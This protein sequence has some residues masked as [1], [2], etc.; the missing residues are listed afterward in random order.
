MSPENPLPNQSVTANIQ[1][2]ITDL[3]SAKITWSING[4]IIKTGTGEKTATF[5]TGA[6]NTTTN[7][8]I[9]IVTSDGQSINKS[10]RLNPVFV[11]LMW[12][13][14]SYTPPFYKGKG[15]FSFQNKITFIAMPHIR[16]S[17]GTEISPKNLVYKWRLNGSVVESAS[18]YGKNTYLFTPTVIARPI[19]VRVEVST[20]NST[21]TG[22]AS[23][24][25]APTEPFINFYEKSPIYGIQFQKSISG[26][27]EME[28]SREIAV[29]AVPY[30][31][32][33]QNPYEGLSYKWSI[34]GKLI[35]TDESQ[36]TRVFRQ[37]ENI[38]GSSN[39][40]LSV[41]AMN[42]ILQF[43]KSSFNIKFNAP[44]ADNTS[45]N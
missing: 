43:T 36:T 29:I 14:E 9:S 45:F 7:I 2:Y 19:D 15:L 20:P 24:S 42:K 13:S 5:S 44:T 26:T 41:E 18:G 4:K 17:N 27:H 16:G 35:D 3:N 21:V 34:N 30:F 12:E 39:I 8:S 40:S 31:F 11:D 22:S 25:I 37:V 10:I 6:E 32:G 28:N 33:T 1:S 38:A 23:I